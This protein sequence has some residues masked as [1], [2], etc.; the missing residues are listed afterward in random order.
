MYRVKIVIG[1]V[2]VVNVTV[3]LVVVGCDL[4][5]HRVKLLWL[6]A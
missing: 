1:Y 4:K 2:P 5:T 3:S 6:E